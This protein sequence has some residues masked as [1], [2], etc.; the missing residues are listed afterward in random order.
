[1]PSII[2]NCRLSPFGVACKLTNFSTR[3]LLRTIQKQAG[4]ITHFAK[5][6]RDRSCVVD[7]IRK[8]WQI[9]VVAIS[10]DQSDSRSWR[11]VVAGG[12]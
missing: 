3:I 2:N 12:D 5:E 10:D 7:W 4:R 9:D 6:V 1:M 8:L 11:K